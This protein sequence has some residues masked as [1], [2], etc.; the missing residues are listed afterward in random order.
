MSITNE[1][2]HNLAKCLYVVMYNQRYCY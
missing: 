2:I 1:I